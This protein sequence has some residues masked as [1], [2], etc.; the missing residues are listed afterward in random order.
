MKNKV[1]IVMPVS[2]PDYIHQ[3]FA[4]LELMDCDN[5]NTS[6]L[7]IVDGDDSLYV[8]A[9]NRTEFSKFTNRLCVKFEDTLGIEKDTILSR[10]LRIS[11]I[12]NQ[13]KKYVGDCDYIMGVEDDTLVPRHALNKLLK[14]YAIYPHAGFIEGVELGRWGT[15]Y[16]G[17]WKSD[18]VYDPKS[19]VSMLPPHDLNQVEEIDSGGFYCFMT[20]REIYMSHIFETFENNTLGPDAE[21]GMSL[22]RMGFMNYI[23]WSINCI[24]RNGDDSIGYPKNIPQQV[25]FAKNDGSWYFKLLK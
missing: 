6:L 19:I 4:Y 13:V 11:E 3:V 25:E 18:D 22:R 21:F 24:H 14:D 16:V 9:R 20:P 8:D 10:R 1:T 23:D 7:V 15:F 2:R 12:H 5:N 17:A